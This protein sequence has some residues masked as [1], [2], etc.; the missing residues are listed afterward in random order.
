MGNQHTKI[1]YA[2]I[3]VD[4]IIGL[5][6]GG[7]SF[8]KIGKILNRQKNHIEDI[9]IDE[10]IWVENR[11][12]IKKHFSSGEICNIINLYQ[13]DLSIKKIS[14]KLKIG[15]SGIDGAYHLDH[16]YSIFEGFI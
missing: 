1:K 2:R 9:L 16:K 10:D 8:T 5:Y 11:N 4:K 12:N 13:S 6:E 3:D 14:V 15:V 7:M